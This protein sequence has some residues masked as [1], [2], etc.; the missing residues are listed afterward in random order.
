MFEVKEKER[1]GALKGD[2]FLA[3][4]S[5]VQVQ[6]IIWQKN[7]GILRQAL[8]SPEKEVKP[9]E[10]L[11]PMVVTV[12]EME[13]RPR[14]KRGVT[15]LVEA[16]NLYPAGSDGSEYTTQ[17]LSQ[18]TSTTLP[19]ISSSQVSSVLSALEPASSQ[20]AG[21]SGPE[22]RAAE[23]QKDK[24]GGEIPP[25]TSS[26]MDTC[27]MEKHETEK[28]RWYR[29]PSCEFVCIDETRAGLHPTSCPSPSST[30][31]RCMACENTFKSVGVLKAHLLID[32]SAP[33]SE[34]LAL[35][36][37]NIAVSDALS[38]DKS[39]KEQEENGGR[40]ED[41]EEAP[42]ERS[43][44]SLFE[45]VDK[46]VVG[47][48]G[49]ERRERT[50]GREV[51]REKRLAKAPKKAAKNVKV[52]KEVGIRCR[53]DGCAIRLLSPSNMEYH[54]QCH[55]GVK[56]KCAECGEEAQSWSN[57]SIHLWKQHSI[58]MELYSCDQCTY[59]TNSLS[60]L[61]NLHRRTHG[62]E[63][64]FLCDLCG[65]GFK[66]TKQL[67][68]HKA[69][70][71]GK[72]K[73]ENEQSV[74]CDICGRAFTGTRMLKYHMDIVHRKLRPYLCSD[75]G[76]S[77]ASKS[78]LRMHA[79]QHTG[80]KPYACNECDYR[81]SD[82]NTLRRHK[83]RHS[84]AKHYTCPHCPYASIQS[85]TFKCHLKN[86]HPGLDEGIMFS[87][88]VCPF[89][90]IKKENFLAH[91]SY[92]SLKAGDSELSKEGEVDLHE[93]NLRNL[94]KEVSNSI[95]PCGG[96]SFLSEN[97]EGRLKAEEILSRE[98]D[99]LLGDTRQSEDIMGDHEP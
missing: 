81:T 62:D 1:T 98:R 40:T 74:S 9:E 48:D 19:T 52:E 45:S 87:C 78:S 95:L 22:R 41:S 10:K 57:L 2:M 29:C 7:E 15:E 5:I 86:K 61:M 83:M 59:K 31:I 43:G 16:I 38:A 63:R 44:F 18:L 30:K 73:R 51:K 65:K 66:T 91:T 42:G 55:N 37:I 53:L 25:S 89:K 84:G 6:P 21:S 3:D 68:N 77:A 90:T 32:H 26:P 82:H 92:H 47:S 75:C 13:E 35:V 96:R 67:R 28:G 76:H 72:E 50:R 79:R 88:E 34:H 99:P 11:V 39:G 54:R 24:V 56:W 80:E 14:N 46:F 23:K 70:H 71:K 4:G 97:P 17:L 12:C 49:T 60:K 33:V 27:R 93:Y 36:A 64:P 20:N 69:V 94:V 8:L 58:D 85:S